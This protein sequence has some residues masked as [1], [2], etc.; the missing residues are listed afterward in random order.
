LPIP[1]STLGRFLV[2]LALGFLPQLVG[3]LATTIRA[4]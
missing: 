2:R 3:A 4:A 1:Y